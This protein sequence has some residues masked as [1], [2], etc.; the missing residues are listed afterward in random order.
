LLSSS[1]VRVY[2]EKEKTVYVDEVGVDIVGIYKRNKMMMLEINK[3]AC[4]DDID[5]P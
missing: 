5:V 2:S 4:D 1:T 3:P